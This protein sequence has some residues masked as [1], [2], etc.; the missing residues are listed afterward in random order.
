MNEK[1]SP[2][3]PRHSAEIVAEILDDSLLQRCKE[4]ASAMN[5]R[6]FSS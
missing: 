2:Q 6:E 5:R 4:K 1:S 3:R